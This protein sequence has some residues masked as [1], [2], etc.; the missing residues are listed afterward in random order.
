MK[1]NTNGRVDILGPIGP[2]FEL[3]DKISIKQCISFRDALTGQWTD[4]L[5]SLTF[6]SKENMQILQ[7]AIRKG[8]YDKS[9]GQYIIA[10]QNCNELN[11]IMR[12]IFLESANNL[13][14]DIKNQIITLNNLVTSFA[15]EQIYNEAISYIKYKIDASTLAI[16]I[17][18]P[19]NTS[20]KTNTL[21]LQPFF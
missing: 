10:P 16:P 13:P 20:P 21:E 3:S 2:Q 6:F 11:I 19:V 9:N 5:L 14:C 1:F 8:V 18:R 17:A 7:N 15:I 4:T 12:S